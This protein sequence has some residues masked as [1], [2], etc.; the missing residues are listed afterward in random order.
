MLEAFIVRA[1]QDGVCVDTG[2]LSRL[3]MVEID[4]ALCARFHDR[5]RKLYSIDF[6]VASVS[7]AD[8]LI[9]ENDTKYDAIIGNPP[10]CNFTDLPDTYK[11]QVKPMFMR[12]ELVPDRRKVLWGGSRM[13]VAALVTVKAL[14]DCCANDGIATLFLPLSLFMNDGAHDAFRSLATTKERFGVKEVHELTSLDVFNGVGTSYCLAVLQNQTRTKFPVN[15]CIYESE[16]NVRHEKARP[17]TSPESC[18]IV[19][20]ENK[21]ARIRVPRESMPRQGVNTC[22]GNDLFFFTECADAGKG[23]S[24]LRNKKREA[25][26]ENELVFPL[27]TSRNFCEERDLVA[28][29]YVFLP[30][31][32]VAGRPLSEAVLKSQFPLAWA[33]LQENEELLRARKGRMIQMQIA[34]GDWWALLGVGP[35]T[36]REYKVVWQS[37][38]KTTFQPKLIEG[39]WVP[40]QS[41]QAYMSFSSRLLAES[42]L[43]LLI[44]SE[45]ETILGASR[46]GGTASWAQPGKVKAFLELV[47][48]IKQPS[49]FDAIYTG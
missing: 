1:R 5:M 8:F 36:F 29:K 34:K 10:W 38:G 44:D 41:L 2:M 9:T 3:K 11:E 25:L 45:I 42:I 46:T 39:R 17:M 37:Y 43:G 13:D 40:N 15:Y 12:Y 16:T 23:G 32:K 14:R 7:H 47:D 21:Q 20:Q 24:Q 18:W 48:D 6:P 30:Y 35:Y 4:A 28:H 33:Y 19:G 27:V 31:D 26:L 22:G 49:L